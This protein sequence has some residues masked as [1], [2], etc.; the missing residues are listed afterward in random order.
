MLGDIELILLD[1]MSYRGRYDS[2]NPT[3]ETMLGA[4]QL[5]WLTTTVNASTADYVVIATSKK[6]GSTGTNDNWGSYQAEFRAILDS[7]TRTNVVFLA[8]DS[9]WP[10]VT[11]QTAADAVAGR[12]FTCVNSS[13][14]AVNWTSGAGPVD[15][16]MGRV[17]WRGHNSTPVSTK[18]DN[19]VGYMYVDQGKLWLEIRDSDNSVWWQAFL[20]EGTNQVRETYAAPGAV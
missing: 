2:G 20:I 16:T 4:Q 5:S 13:P 7:F 14:A 19:M 15:D 12:S 8:G 10:C 1:Y 3:D 17:L 9:H 18:T 6:I 11:I